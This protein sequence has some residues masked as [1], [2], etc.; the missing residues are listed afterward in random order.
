MVINNPASPVAIEDAQI[1]SSPA[2]TPSIV[3]FTIRNRVEQPLLF[4]SVDAVLFDGRGKIRSV[5]GMVEPTGLLQAQSKTEQIVLLKANP[6]RDWR[7]VLSPLQ[8]KFKTGAW[9]TDSVAD[10]KALIAAQ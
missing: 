2:G 6:Q 3:Q 10:A 9:R 1:I 8:V 5:L 7:I 4:A